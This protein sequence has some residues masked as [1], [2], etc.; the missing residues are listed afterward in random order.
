ME[1]AATEVGLVGAVV[2]GDSRLWVREEGREMRWEG[3]CVV[4][5]W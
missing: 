2:E 5:G 1:M 4:V 3:V